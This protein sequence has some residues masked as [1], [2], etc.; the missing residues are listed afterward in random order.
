MATMLAMNNVPIALS[1]EL[2]PLFS[3]IFPDSEIAK[4]FSSHHTKTACM[5]NGA[6]AP[7]YQQQ[8]VGC[9][10][11]DPFALAFNGSSDSS[12]EKMNPLTVWLFDNVSAIVCTRLLA[13]LLLLQPIPYFPK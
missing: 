1:E 9:M 8:L 4:Q 11:K 10:K 2:T 7:H 12:V 5:I 13:C 6:I 3:D